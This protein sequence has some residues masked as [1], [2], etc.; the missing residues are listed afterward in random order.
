M[1]V[2]RRKPVDDRSENYFT[3]AKLN[4]YFYRKNATFLKD[5]VKT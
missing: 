5:R 2:H 3:D 1:F 4:Y